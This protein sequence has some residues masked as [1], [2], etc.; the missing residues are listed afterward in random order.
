MVLKLCLSQNKNGEKCLV[1]CY[2]HLYSKEQ[3]VS[4]TLQGCI[5]SLNII[6]ESYLTV[7]FFPALAIIL[8]FVALP[9]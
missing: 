5:L 7:L 6:T 4:N 1:V 9:F 2:S 8:N 3:N